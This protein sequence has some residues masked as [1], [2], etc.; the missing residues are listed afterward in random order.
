[1]AGIKQF[2]AL[3]ADDAMAFAGTPIDAAKAFFAQ[4]PKKRKCDIIEGVREGIFFTVA[5]GATRKG[6]YPNRWVGITPKTIDTIKYQPTDSSGS[7][8]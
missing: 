2:R 7:E 6:N 4:Y 8:K 5:W 1:M 3:G